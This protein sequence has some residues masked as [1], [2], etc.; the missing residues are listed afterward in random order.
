MDPTNL[1]ERTTPHYSLYQKQI[2]INGRHGEYP[3]FNT[4]PAYMEQESNKVLSEGGWHYA[5]SNAGQY[6]T[7]RANKESFYHWRIIPRMLRQTSA[8]D[9]TTT[10]F[11]FK[12]PMPIGFAPIVAGELGLP[13]CLSTAGSSSIEDVAASN[14][15]GSKKREH[16]YGTDENGNKVESKIS[17]LKSK[18]AAKSGPRFF[19]LYLPHDDELTI[20]MLTRAHNSGFDVCILT[21]DTWQLAWRHNDIATANYAFYK[22]MGAEL[23]TSDPVFMKRMKDLNI[24][25]PKVIGEKWI[26]SVWHGR[27]HTW[28]KI[29]W[30]I[31]QWKKISNNKPFC[32]KG[33][34]CAEDALLALKIGVDG[35]VV[36]NHA[37]R[38]VDGAVASLDALPDIVSAVGDKMTVMFDSG[39]RSASDVFKAIALGA[40]CVF[41]GRLWV[42]GL[43]LRGEQGVRHVMKSL[44]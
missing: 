17:Y 40:K 30:V 33:I 29:P 26:D 3:I 38:Q 11:G 19:Q 28:E 4:D 13:Y 7:D 31:E 9:T 44:M 1:G 12:I 22:G 14:H 6:Q 23:G 34:Q 43:S 15:E 25:D 10:L 36:S 16:G 35:I 18:D 24:D 8:R 2:F 5:A 37:G 20:S 41:V 39:V 27:S 21:L 42:W 32:L